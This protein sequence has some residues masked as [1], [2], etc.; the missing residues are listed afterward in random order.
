MARPSKEFRLKRNGDSTQAYIR[1]VYVGSLPTA[2]LCQ[3]IK[4][5]SGR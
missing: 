4:E 2:E 5:R 1:G 3:Y